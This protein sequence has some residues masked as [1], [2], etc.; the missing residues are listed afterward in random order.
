MNAVGEYFLSIG[1]DIASPYFRWRHNRERK[2]RREIEL[3]AKLAALKTG[4]YSLECKLAAA[5]GVSVEAYRADC[6]AGRRR[7]EMHLV[8]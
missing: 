8:H 3:A 1:Y 5:R 6:E 7:K 2:R 4:A